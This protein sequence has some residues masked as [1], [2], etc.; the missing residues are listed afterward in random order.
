M[1]KYDSF[2]SYIE[3][4]NE[5]SRQLLIEL[6]EI[7]LEAL[8]NAK[9]AM[10]YGAPAFELKENAKLKD[11]IMIGGYKN[12]VSLYPYPDTLKVFKSKLTKYKVLEGTI[13][14]SN[15]EELPKELIKEMVIFRYNEVN[16]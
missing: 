16:K 1:I 12:H 9:E 5:R 4:Q 11:K 14:F 13:Q 15:K 10:S 8:P 2:I 3:A 7:I 6:R